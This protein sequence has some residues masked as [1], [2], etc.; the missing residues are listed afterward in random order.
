MRLSIIT[1]LGISYH[2]INH[3]KLSSQEVVLLLYLVV[4]HSLSILTIKHIV[5]A[6]YV[7]LRMRLSIITALGISYHTINHPKLSSQ[8]VVLLLSLVGSHSPADVPF[9]PLNQDN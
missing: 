6:N 4:F 5:P 1:A 2:T 8:E 3:P 7:Q 9:V